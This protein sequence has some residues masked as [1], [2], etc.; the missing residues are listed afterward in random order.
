MPARRD[1]ANAIRALSMDAVQQANSGHPGM[2]M[3]MADIAEVLWN[4][5]LE[6]NPANPAWPDR[7]RFVLSNG[8]G[9]MLLYSVLHLAGYDL[10]MEQLRRFRQLH[11]QTP[12]HPELHEAPGVETTTGP[13]GQGIANAVGMA[14]AERWWAAKA[15]REDDPVIDHTTYAIVTDGDLENLDEGPDLVVHQ[16][17]EILDGMDE[18][19]TTHHGDSGLTDLVRSSG[20]DEKA[21]EQQIRTICPG[22]TDAGTLTVLWSIGTDMIQGEFLQEPSRE[23]GYDFAAMGM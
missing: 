15:N 4:D 12:G 11:G 22:V 2:P 21:A 13:L 3:G 5:Y 23:R 19:N 18:W 20:L 1:L 14:V 16:A 9:S 6:H 17:D 7:D 10:P 8:H